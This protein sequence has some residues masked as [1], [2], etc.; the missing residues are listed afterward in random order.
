MASSFLPL[1]IIPTQQLVICTYV[2]LAL[3]A[4]ES[5]I[6]FRMAKWQERQ[7]T[8]QA[9]GAAAGAAVCAAD[10]CCMPVKVQETDAGL[11]CQTGCVQAKMRPRLW[12]AVAS[13]QRPRPTC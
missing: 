8:A 1:Q 11:H 9:S 5:L 3:V 6:V 7:E 10:F 13:C 12:H 2:L 4:I